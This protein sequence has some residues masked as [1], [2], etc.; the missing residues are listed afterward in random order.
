MIEVYKYAQTRLKEAGLYTS[1][2][3]GVLG[4]GTRKAVDQAGSWESWWN[5]ERR[6]IAYIQTLAKKEGFDPGVID[7]RWGPR[8]KSAYD[9]LA[10]NDSKF[11]LEDPPKVGNWPKE[12]TNSLMQYYGNVGTDQ[13]LITLPYPMVLDWNTSSSITKMSCHRKVASAVEQIF[14]NTLDYYGMSEIKKLGLNQFGG[15]LNVRPI[16]GGNRWSTHSW[17]IAIDLD[18]DNNRLSWGREKA[19]LAKPEYDK[20]WGFVEEVG[21]YSLGRRKNFDWMHFQFCYR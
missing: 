1:V 9:K 16:R 7:G 18:P 4:S 15:C 3:D 13:T 14:S 6:I 5:T 17:G 10:G 11:V 20:F 19:K 12:T 21:G 8:T 2:A